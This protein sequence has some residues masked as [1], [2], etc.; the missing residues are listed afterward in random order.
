[1]A[2]AEAA[3]ELGNYYHLILYQIFFCLIKHPKS[4]V[5]FDSIYFTF[6]ALWI[7]VMVLLAWTAWHFIHMI[8]GW[9]KVIWVMTTHI[10]FSNN[11]VQ[12]HVCNSHGPLESSKI[13]IP[14]VQTYLIGHNISFDQA[15][16][17]Y[18]G[19]TQIQH[20]RLMVH[21]TEKRKTLF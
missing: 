17:H 18:E 5:G 4:Q 1:M 9:F 21:H 6:L 2:G 15:Q 13:R 12:T 16:C 11:L 3:T 20:C 10:S 19:K 14:T 7:G 8:W